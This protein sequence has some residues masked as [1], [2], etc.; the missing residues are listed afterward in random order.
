[1]KQNTRRS[2]PRIAPRSA[3]SLSVSRISLLWARPAPR[4]VH[5]LHRKTRNSTRLT[6]RMQTTHHISRGI[7]V[8]ASGDSLGFLPR[9]TDASCEVF[10]KMDQQ[11]AT[12]WPTRWPWLGRKYWPRLFTLPGR[13]NSVKF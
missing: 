1:M 12:G 8:S 2:F 7:P 4:Q 5:G 10:H 6:F 13:S 9:P 3:S 11:Q